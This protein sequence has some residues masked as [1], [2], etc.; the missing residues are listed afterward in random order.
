MQL[1]RVGEEG[2]TSCSNFLRDFFAFAYFLTISG[3]LVMVLTAS[4][5]PQACIE[6]LVSVIPSNT[7]DVR[8]SLR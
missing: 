4:Q 7:G 5:L 2:R 3:S 8:W 1:E 6:A